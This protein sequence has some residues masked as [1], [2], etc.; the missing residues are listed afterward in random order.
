MKREKVK[1]KEKERKKER[2]IGEKKS[3]LKREIIYFRKIFFIYR[4]KIISKHFESFRR[5]SF[6]QPS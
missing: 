2:K 1:E 4:V 6:S 5:H 3:L